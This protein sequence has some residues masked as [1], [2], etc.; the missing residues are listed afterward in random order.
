MFNKEPD[1]RDEYLGN[2]MYLDGEY[3]KIWF[4]DMSDDL[5]VVF[6]FGWI[7]L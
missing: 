7:C 3:I 6:D 4:R 5:S 2:G 1:F